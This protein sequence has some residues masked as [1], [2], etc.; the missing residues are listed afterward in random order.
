MKSDVNEEADGISL[1]TRS[2]LDNLTAAHPRPSVQHI[3]SNPHPHPRHHQHQQTSL[4]G[5]VVNIAVASTTIPGPAALVA[6]A[7]RSVQQQVASGLTTFAVT[8]KPVANLQSVN[9]T[10]SSPLLVDLLPQQQLQ[11]QQQQQLLLR[12][13]VSSSGP[14]A[15]AVNNNSGGTNTVAA[16]SASGGTADAPSSAEV[17]SHHPADMADK[18]KQ[19]GRMSRMHSSSLSSSTEASSYPASSLT[20]PVAVATAATAAETTNTTTNLTLAASVT[21][22]NV[23]TGAP[24]NATALSNQTLTVPNAA[25]PIIPSGIESEEQV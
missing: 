9:T 16:G 13:H 3:Q 24:L 12:N 10:V 17:G 21:V 23:R 2:S 25:V 15:V 14:A 1:G 18:V 11:Q 5:Q 20:T 22:L 7:P 4:A 6:G 8:G 19:S